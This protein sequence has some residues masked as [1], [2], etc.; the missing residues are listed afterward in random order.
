MPKQRITKEM[1]VEAAFELTRTEGVEAATVKQIAERLG[2]SV[3]PIYSY[4]DSMDGLRREAAKRTNAFIQQYIS[5]RIDPTDFFRSTGYA[6]LSLAREEKHLFQLFITQTREGIAGFDDL[7]RTHTDPRVAG[8]IAQALH[9]SQ[10]AARELHLNMLIYTI[11]IGT[12]LA[13]VKPGIIDEEVAAQ[14]ENAHQAFLQQT[15]ERGTKS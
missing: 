14:L 6:Y 7:Y 11:G 2:C 12:I 10:E 4:C 5:S 15:L 13:T 3:Q 9:V 8:C 1:V